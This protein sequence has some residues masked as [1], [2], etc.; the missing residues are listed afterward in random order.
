M[1]NLKIIKKDPLRFL[2]SGPAGSGIL[3][4]G[5]ILSSALNSAGY[6][7]QVYPE[8]PSRIRG[9][10]N[11]IQIVVSS[12]PQIALSGKMDVILTMDEILKKAHSSELI[13]GGTILSSDD[14][15]L[16]E[17]EPMKSNPI[18]KNAFFAGLI[19][20]ICLQDEAILFSMIKKILQ[21]KY[22]DLNL[23]A[24]HLGFQTETATQ[25]KIKSARGKIVSKTGNEQFA[26]SALDAKV[27]YASIYPMTP[28]TSLLAFL[29]K[30]KIKMLI[31]EDEIF[32]AISTLG[33][34]Y[35]GHR[36]LTATSGGGF[37]LMGEAIGFS[38]MAEIPLVVILGQRTGPSSGMAT[39]SS[40]A[41]LNFAI[42][43]SHGEGQK[44]VFAPGDLAEISQLTQTAFNLA[45]KFQIPVIILTDKFLSESIFSSAK[46]ELDQIKI[47]IDRGKKTNLKKEY[48]RYADCKDGISP[49]AYPGD[50]AH[51]TNSY[52]H[53]EH[54][55]S[56]DDSETRERMVLKRSRKIKN[57]P[58]GYSVF[59][60]KTASKV[61]VS[62]GST[63]I[64]ILEFIFEN[65]QYK[66]LHINRVWP[67]DENIKAE[68]AG[69]KQIAVV[70]NN[71]TGQMAR[72]IESKMHVRV[73]SLLKDDGRPFFKEDLEKI[74]K[75]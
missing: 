73:K 75:L 29:A 42:N 33:A 43:S 66:F 38:S 5:E 51:L 3:Q 44:I 56:I 41:D 15:K 52:E 2:I 28:I 40:Q 7:T 68:L 18:V 21:G 35:A 70:E 46:A 22:V 59:G 57:L 60:K 61:I 72:I 13:P 39:Y 54:G 32:A 64:P 49:R 69:A 50:V 55:F 1:K 4:L 20:K 19:W 6:F 16:F 48:S 12:K 34:S 14:L 74:K 31:P 47:K 53:D 24:A 8:Y 36:A 23:E 30:T 62:W 27:E 63:K 65:K 58:K 26:S 11:N 25:Y 9:G 37:C 45:D 10:D 17:L 67:F 71:S